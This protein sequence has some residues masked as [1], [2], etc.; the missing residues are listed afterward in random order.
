MCSV[1]WNADKR[2][3]ALW[4]IRNPSSAIKQLQLDRATAFLLPFF[5]EATG[6][7]F[8]VEKGTQTFYYE[9]LSAE[10]YAYKCD[11]YSSKINQGSACMLPKRVCD[12]MKC[13]VARFL[14]CSKDQVNTT[15]F[16]VPRKF[17]RYIL[18]MLLL[19]YVREMSSKRIFSLQST[20]EQDNP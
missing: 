4:D 2:E 13:E 19:T 1:G 11:V 20:M 17:V 16:T 5:E 8:L 9:I 15:Y 6:L 7:L 18:L 10:P 14:Y 3:L 12:V